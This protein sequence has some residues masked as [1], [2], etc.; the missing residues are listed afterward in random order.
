MFEKRLGAKHKEREISRCFFL[1]SHF[2]FFLSCCIFWGDAPFCF[3][4]FFFLWVRFCSKLHVVFYCL[5]LPQQAQ[6][7][8]AMFHDAMDMLS[9]PESVKEAEKMMQDPEFKSEISAYMDTLRSNDVFK[10]AMAEAQRK[11]MVWSCLGLGLG[12]VLLVVL[13]LIC[14]WVWWWLC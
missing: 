6:Q 7:N 2:P 12:S 1:N 5:F 14:V 13:M 11:Y 9:D 3:P 8:P 10:Q 4:A